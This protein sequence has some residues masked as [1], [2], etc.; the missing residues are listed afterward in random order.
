MI[1]GGNESG[2]SSSATAAPSTNGNPKIVATYDY[3]DERGVLLYQTVRRE[4]KDFRQRRPTGKD[5]WEWSLDDV[6]RVLYRLP[7]LIAA[8]KDKQ[9]FIVEGEKDVDRLHDLGLCATCNAMGAG[10]WKAEYNE[11]LRDRHVTII[12]DNDKPGREHAKQVARQLHKI[13]ASV[14]ILSL[15]NLLDKEDVS[16][17]LDKGGTAEMLTELAAEAEPWL[18][19]LPPLVIREAKPANPPATAREAMPVSKCLADVESEDVDWL[20]ENRIARKAMTILDGDPGLGKSTL[21]LDLA[22]RV[23]RGWAMP[24]GGGS[25]AQGVAGAVL[26]LSG[27]CCPST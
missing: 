9:V 19:D 26:I 1:V 21:T 2:K 11:S 15:P 8:P 20:W 24:P 14:H 4:P 23:S 18:D 3:R 13:A 22:A 10:K 27:W 17:F 12:P 7:E 6:R 16:D 25:D 5:K